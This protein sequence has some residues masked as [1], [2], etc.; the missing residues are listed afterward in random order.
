MI[1]AFHD[2]VV[3]CKQ[4]NW[5]EPSYDNSSLNH[6][7]RMCAGE[8]LF[9]STMVPARFWDNRPWHRV[10][11]SWTKKDDLRIRT[12]GYKNLKDSI[13]FP[14]ESS[15][16]WLPSGS[17]PTCLASGNSGL[18]LTVMLRALCS[19]YSMFTEWFELTH[20]K[21]DRR[22]RMTVKGL[23]SLPARPQRIVQKGGLRTR[24]PM[25]IET[26]SSKGFPEDTPISSDDVS[27]RFAGNAVTFNLF[28]ELFTLVCSHLEEAG[29]S[30]R[31]IPNESQYSI[32]LD[33]PF[34]L[35]DYISNKG[36]LG[37]GAKKGH[38]IV[39][40]VTRERE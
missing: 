24:R 6:S 1:V 21:K 38:N 18:V 31:L 4:W 11:E 13:G 19:L 35:H 39:H 20:S 14:M 12:V 10:K 23:H 29:V 40:N 9:P 7:N 2:S 32:W 36:K 3:F 33:E 25:P 22:K 15:N 16:V 8:V 17:F 37:A 30:K 34:H 27:F 26:L 28:T 5:P